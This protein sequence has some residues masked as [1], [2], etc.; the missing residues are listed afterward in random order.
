MRIANNVRFLY[1]GLTFLLIAFVVKWFGT[2]IPSYY[3]WIL[4]GIAVVLKAVF[5][6][7]VFREKGFK[8]ALW[9]YLILT[10]VALIFI[11]MFFKYICPISV[12]QQLLFYGAIVLK[13]AGLI[14]MFAQRR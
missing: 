10:G 3:F 8:P 14:L 7:N 12:L 11:S 9:L 13:V 1:A 2:A 4:I 6:I 5:L